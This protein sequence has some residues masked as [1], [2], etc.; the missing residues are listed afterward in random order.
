MRE[1][2]FAIRRL[3]KSPLQLSAGILA[4]M[5]GIGINTAMFSLADAL[6]FHP[7]EL[8][9]LHRLLIFD[10]TSRGKQL[11]IDD[12]SPA[13]FIDYQ[14]SLK[15]FSSLALLRHWDANITRDAEPEQLRGARVTANWLDTLGA[16]IIA[17]RGFRPG[18]DQPGNNRVVVLSHALW[19]SRYAADPKL[20]G[21][22]ILL[23][24][25]EFQVV[26]I[27]K[28]TS[29]YPGYIQVFSPYP[30]TPEF[31]HRRN[32]FDCMVLGRLKDGVSLATAQAELNSLQKGIAD[33]FKSSHEG[34][35]IQLVPLA[36]RV[37]GSNDMGTRYIIMLIFAASFAL[38]IACANVANLQLARVSGRSREFAILSA[39]GA[40]RW[41]IA[42]Q[43]LI[44][45]LIL[46]GS[47]ALLGAL[48]SAWCVD[49]IKKLLPVEIWQFIP[50]WPYVH[51]NANAVA[52]TS[53]MALASGLI[54]GVAPAFQSSKAD[55]QQSLREG[56]RS[57]SS[58][59]GRQW[60]RAALV[61]FQMTLALVLLIGAGLM[62][63]GAHASISQF[64]NKQPEQV[65]TMQI[66]L[67]AKKYD[68]KEK[69]LEFIRRVQ[70][71]LSRLPGV[72]SFAL[73]NYIP[74][75]DNGSSTY[76]YLEGQ[77]E[78]PIALR[79]TAINQL[80]S[81]GYFS[82]MRIPLRS[83]RL[84]NDQDSEERESVCLIDDILLASSFAGQD[85]LGRRIVPTSGPVKTPCRI[86]GVVGSEKHFAWENGARQTIYR[87]VSQI[88][89]ASVS[90]LVRASGPVK[91]M[92]AAIKQAVFAVDPDQPVRQAFHYQELIDNTLAGL[93]M[94]AILMSGIGIVALVLACLGIYSVM[95]YTVSERTSEIGMRIAMGAQPSDVFRLLG[96]QAL[97]MGG[98][99]MALGLTIGY[100][101]AQIFSSLLFGVS[102][103]DFWSLSS[104]SILLAL[105]AGLALYIPARRAIQMDPATA[106]R[107]D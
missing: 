41:P 29:R 50:M 80:V 45:S 19:T 4:F 61:A 54:A 71:E 33:R 90:I 88:G 28:Q 102:P 17:G 64:A 84:L 103:N 75:S 56:G 96:K 51:V 22:N 76:F 94:I 86:V 74:L 83:G 12:I 5:L 98:A 104:V 24:N 52:I 36:E 65:A 67:P 100:A 107:H 81:L 40:G 42:R 15:S 60:F 105:V 106:L 8:P 78:P 21:R 95:S 47:G 34:R 2:K 46:S 32:D 37:A 18:E 58:G 20:I 39:L 99:G 1:I 25:E 66:I 3:L 87:P 70:Q 62:V 57:M 23:N 27:V 63:R 6:L 97:I 35:Q 77:P 10:A 26:G 48:L 55:A 68:T 85:P 43:V 13:D 93:K 44:E 69:R 101:M 82:L 73:A 14:S 92:L 30:L 72:Q 91:P 49:F 31:E 16:T 38:L 59:T 89:Q 7:L 9:E 53:L 79:N 11:G